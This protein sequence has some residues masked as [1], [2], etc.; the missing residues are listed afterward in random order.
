MPEA[1][2]LA[3]LPRLLTERQAA[4]ALGVSI[5]TLRRERKRRRIG[6]AMIAERPR[7][8]DQHLAAYLSAREIQPCDESNNLTGRGRSA[9]IGSAGAPTAPC[10]AEPGST[11]GH[12]KLAEHRS[13]LA[14]LQPQASRLRSGLPTTSPRTTP[15]LRTSA[16]AESLPDTTNATPNTES[17]PMPSGSASP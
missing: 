7:Y 15:P 12:D 9:N 3:R 6:Y 16:S 8:T 1:T 5:E 13:A 4:V 11:P 14:T 10:G 2:E 17:A